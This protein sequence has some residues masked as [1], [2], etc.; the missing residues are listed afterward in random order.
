MPIQFPQEVGLRDARRVIIRPFTS[1]DADAL[2][3]FFQTLPETMRRGAWDRLEARETLATWL[4]DME[5]E[6]VTSLLAL[7]G[8][9]IVADASMHYRR[10]GP[11][12]FVGRVKWLIDPAWQGMGVGTAVLT[13]F[14]HM[15]RENGLRHLT[16]MLVEGLED[17]AVKTL[18]GMGFR[19]HRIPHYGADPDGRPRD[20]LKM[21]LAL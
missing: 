17:A 4:Q 8:T 11:L 21:V 7:D 6:Q 15:A 10:Y 14:I 18:E 3:D 19:T 16:C 20:M 5:H 1:H 13:D 9:R 2:F 12:R